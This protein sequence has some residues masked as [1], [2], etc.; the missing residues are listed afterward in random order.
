MLQWIQN[1]D[2]QSVSFIQAHLHGPVLDKL[3]PFISRIGNL[4]AIWLAIAVIFLLIPK[5]RKHGIMIVLGV[6]LAAL[7][8]EL[9]LKHLVQ[10]VRPCNVNSLVPML[11]ARPADF[12]FPSG[13]T[14]A[15]FAATVV[16]WKANKKLGIAAL[17]LAVLIAFS[18]LYLFVHYPTDILAGAALGLAC[19][20][21]AVKLY[22]KFSERSPLAAK[23]R[24]R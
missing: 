21:I 22:N 14:S 4:G 24:L 6:L 16:M 17:L 8:G 18:R 9:V 13:H 12:S 1:L 19:G 23:L 5:Y 2:N 11:I 10:R 15:S 3:M 20:M 7:T